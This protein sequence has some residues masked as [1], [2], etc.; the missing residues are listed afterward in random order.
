MRFTARAP[1]PTLA[2]ISTLLALASAPS[3][4]AWS[5]PTNLGAPVNS[6]EDEYGMTLGSDGLTLIF[7]SNRPGG[8]G[9]NDL[10]SSTW[11]GST[12]MLPVGLGAGING[13]GVEYA[14]SLSSD[15]LTLY[16]TGND[17][18]IYSST[19][20]GGVWG[21]KAK[22]T[23]LSSTS[24]DWSP[25]VSYDG[26]TMILTIW[27]RAGGFGDHDIWIST[28]SGVTW[29]P[30]V[31]AGAAVN[32]AGSEYAGSLSVT[33]DSLYFAR[34]GDL[35]LSIK[36]G[37]TWQAA[38]ALEG[39]IQSDWYDS[40]PVATK[41]GRT[42]YFS[43]DRPGGLGKYDLWTSD[44]LEGSSVPGDGLPVARAFILAGENPVHRLAELRLDLPVAQAADVAV[45][46]I[47]GRR[48]RQ[49]GR[50]A[51]EPGRH[52]F[53]WDGVDERGERL[54]SGVYLARAAGR[55][56]Q[57]TQKLIWVR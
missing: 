31:N 40:H 11:N 43:S 54:S 28:K 34:S 3:L 14:P 19:K 5:T 48:V 50:G 27:R 35:Y 7:D 9:K 36:V 32:T 12:W 39:S 10:Y 51:L 18:D 57:S 46:D 33:G 15:G 42:L 1:F 26:N 8:A 52:L 44:R 17:W 30:P 49:L 22:V 55:D 2:A 45:F 53:S 25:G 21:A 41:N 23:T 20:S 29:G 6:A 16:L 24:Q 13:S 4:A 47:L 37:G 38:T 56:W